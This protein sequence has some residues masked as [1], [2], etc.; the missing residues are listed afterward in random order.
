MISAILDLVMGAFLLLYPLTNMVILLAFVM[1]IWLLNKGT[2][3]VG[4]SL[5]LKSWD[6]KGRGIFL[7]SG[8][9]ILI[10][11]LLILI[12]PIF[13]EMSILFSTALAFLT[14]G[15]FNIA[16]GD[17]LILANSVEHMN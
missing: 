6:V 10:S 4:I 7:V 15:I 14:L 16:L 1:A 2:F 5:N 17:Y 11:T 3:A 13:G 8:I 9:G 12:Y